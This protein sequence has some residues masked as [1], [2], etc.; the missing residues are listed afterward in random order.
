M[1]HH[2]FLVTLCV[3]Q[4]GVLLDARF[5]E[6]FE[7]EHLAILHVHGLQNE[8]YRVP[9]KTL[10]WKCIEGKE[11]AFKER[12]PNFLHRLFIEVQEKQENLNAQTFC[13]TI[14]RK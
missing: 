4:T 6:L 9:T 1:A 12:I 11:D 14:S 7:L 10:Q 5:P 2:Q 3:Y 13:V 8:D